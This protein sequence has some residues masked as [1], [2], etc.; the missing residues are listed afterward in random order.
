[1]IALDTLITEPEV[2]RLLNNR[3]I[4]ACHRAD[5][6]TW[7]DLLT[8]DD[9]ELLG[10][11]QIGLKT[12]TDIKAIQKAH[13]NEIPPKENVDAESQTDSNSTDGYVDNVHLIEYHLQRYKHLHPRQKTPFEALAV[14]RYELLSQ[15]AKNVF[16]RWAKM[17][18]V[19]SIVF[20]N[21]RYRFVKERNCGKRTELELEAFFSTIQTYFEQSID[22]SDVV[23][24]NAEYD[25]AIQIEK[26]NQDFSSFLLPQ[27][28]EFAIQRINDGMEVPILYIWRKYILQSEDRKDKIRCEYFGLDPIQKCKSMAEIATSMGITTERVRQLLAANYEVPEAFAVYQS[29]IR[30]KIEDVVSDRSPI[31]ESLQKDNLLVDFPNRTMRLVCSFLND[32][33]V[34]HLEDDVPEYIVKKNI[35]ENIKVG[36]TRAKL[37]QIINLQKSKE[38]ELDITTVF[39]YEDEAKQP[40]NVEGVCKLFEDYVREKFSLS[41]KNHTVLIPPSKLISQD[42]EIIL[43]QSPIAKETVETINKPHY[44]K[45]LQNN[46]A[47]SSSLESNENDERNLDRRCSVDKRF[48][49]FKVFV[50][51]NN[52][53]P[54]LIGENEEVTLAR[55]LGNVQH[56]RIDTTSEQEIEIKQFLEQ[57]KELPQNGTEYQFLQNCERIKDIVAKTQRLPKQTEYSS[58][59]QWFMKYQRLYKTLLDNRKRFFEDLLQYLHKICN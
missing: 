58:E 38:R 23:R 26:I 2:A 45:V 11:S 54:N 17:E 43:K 32:Y 28:L 18:E 12:V 7:R 9:Q 40:D 56:G 27:E 51:T 50:A 57:N 35:L 20:S 10:I 47:I 13:A 16:P 30:A 15:R 59:Y 44:L 22:W 24:D 46:Y 29:S 39:Q 34:V 31:W 8:A 21:Q 25:L 3:I 49:E 19:I 48:K 42:N 6:K 52:R 36:A 5:I 14:E 1:M 41:I 53:I 33:K 55:W 4:S 37:C